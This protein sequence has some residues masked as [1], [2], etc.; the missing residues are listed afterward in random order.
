VY[1]GLAE[2]PFVENALLPMQSTSATEAYKKVWEILGFHFAERAGIDVA[3][4]RVP[5]IYGPLYYSMVNLPS[6]LCHAAARGAEPDFRGAIGGVPK[7]DTEMDFLFVKDCAHGLALLQL[8]ENLAHRV[9]NFGVGHAVKLGELRDA[10]L[11][12]EPN[13]EIKLE[14]GGG[15]AQSPQRYLDIS[16][17]RADLAF[18]PAYDIKRGVAEYLHWLAGH[19]Q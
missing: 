8:A 16:R 17:A 7:E 2:G 6:R 4:A 12:V 3:A 1:G 19:P 13:A 9:Y 18:E 15:T 14:S 11:D 5:G 10:I